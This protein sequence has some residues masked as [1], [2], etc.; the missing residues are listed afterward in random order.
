MGITYFKRFRM[1]ID[2]LG[3]LFEVAPLPLAYHLLPWDECLLQEHAKVKYHSFCCEIDANVFPCLGD[4]EG[5]SRLMSDISR[6]EDFVAE[7]TW[8]VQFD[9]V[10]RSGSLSCGTIQGILD[11][12]GSGSIQNV[13]VIPSHRG[14]GIGKWLI[15]NA[16]RGFRDIGLKKAFLEVTAQN[17]GAVRLYRQLGFRKVRT[18]YKAAEVACV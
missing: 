17:T 9:E 12:N 5:C 18:V 1:E 11:R 15:L 8:L 10:G 14:C 2:L 13:G 3:T 16:L 6:R 4:P 7:A